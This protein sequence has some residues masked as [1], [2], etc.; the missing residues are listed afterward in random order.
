MNPELPISKRENE[1]LELKSAAALRAPETIARGAVAMLNSEGGDVWIGFNEGKSTNEVEAISLTES[2]RERRRLQ[3]YLL[4]VIEPTP[5]EGEVS[6]T[7]LP[8]GNGSEEMGQVLRVTMKPIPERRPYAFRRH[9]GRY[10]VRRVGDRIVPMSR[11]DIGSHFRRMPISTTPDEARKELQR[12]IQALIAGPP[13]RFWLGIE[14]GAGAELKLG[15][16]RETELLT[17]PTVSGA[18]RGSFNF[19]AAAYRGAARIIK[20]GGKAALTIGDEV[21]SLRVF[22][23]GGVRFEAALEEIFW[24]GRV[25]FVNAERLLSPEALLGYLISVPRLVGTLLRDTA[26]W[27][28]LPQGDLWAALGITG[29]RGWGLLPGDLA[30]WPQYRYQIRRFQ[31]NDLQESLR[32]TQDDLRE[33]PDECGMRLVERVYHAFEIDRMPSIDGAAPGHA[34]LPALGRDGYSRWVRLDLGGVRKVARLRR[35]NLG[36]NR[37]EW[38]TQDGDQ[39]PAD[40]RWIH[41][42]SYVE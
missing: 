7:T 16:L 25:P 5:V 33:R 4:D 19:T 24:V 1:T 29:L 39:I 35:D 38:E 26:L 41:G 9:G 42:W 11:E 32:F 23:N 27:N 15:E 12:E 6:V 30:E 14:P 31:D 10:F 21:L 36:D 18:P 20:P 3:D 40:G 22:R 17:D 34:G 2:E 28:H 13:D 37:L 8:L